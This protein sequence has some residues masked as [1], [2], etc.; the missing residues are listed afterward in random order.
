MHR[1]FIMH[2]DRQFNWLRFVVPDEKTDGIKKE[3]AEPTSSLLSP[4]ITPSKPTVSVTSS[5]SSFHSGSTSSLTGIKQLRPYH[6]YHEEALN[7]M[8]TATPVYGT[9]PNS[10]MRGGTRT[11]SHQPAERRSSDGDEHNTYTLSHPFMNDSYLSTMNDP[12]SELRPAS[13]SSSLTSTLTGAMGGTNTSVHSRQSRSPPGA[14][15]SNVQ[16]HDITWGT[17]PTNVT[18]TMNNATYP[19]V[20]GH[21]MPVYDMASASISNLPFDDYATA[22]HA[23]PESLSPPSPPYLQTFNDQQYGI[24]TRAQLTASG[25]VGYPGQC[26]PTSYQQPMDMSLSSEDLSENEIRQLRRRVR[27]L[28]LEY[29]RS[30][31]ALEAMRGSIANSTSS[32][33]PSFKASRK[34]RTEARKKVYCSLNRAG[35]ALCAWHDSRRERRAYP[36][37][38]APPGY[39]NCGCTFE[40]ALFEES[41]SSHGVGSYHP[42]ETV[43]MDPALRNPLL[44]LLEKR[45]G[46]KDGDFEHNT[47]T[48]E[49][50]E[51]ES[52]S[53]WEQKA[54]SGQTARRRP[55]SERH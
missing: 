17:N 32:H 54:H 42:G 34:A 21:S 18:T 8:S 52:P 51:G 50:A 26:L 41:L 38:N 36:P 12:S 19:G 28:E 10:G 55:E 43:R 39:L 47:A 35:N 2:D 4:P 40:E 23:S 46:Y 1:I 14:Y 7:I 15:G 45:Y 37:R 31:S 27:E 16:N 30:R 29:G 53:V 22:R 48:G 3:I 49:W 6:S 13:S 33:S 9:W 44:K 5:P 11:H 20:A 24:P 25:A